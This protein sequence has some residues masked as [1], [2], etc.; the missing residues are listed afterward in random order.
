MTP[1]ELS[2]SSIRD[3]K[4]AF[5]IPQ[6]ALSFSNSKSGNKVQ[7]QLDPESQAS[8]ANSTL[9]QVGDHIDLDLRT[10][11]YD[12]E[13][14]NNKFKSFVQDLINLQLAT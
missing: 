6:Q 8:Q 3:Q 13:V 9:S 4:E 2:A 12:Q 7:R 11:D 5:P 1:Q 10:P 14:V